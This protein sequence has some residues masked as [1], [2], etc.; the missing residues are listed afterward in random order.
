MTN[1][2]R[3]CGVIIDTGTS[4]EKCIILGTFRNAKNPVYTLIGGSINRNETPWDAFKREFYEETGMDP[5]Q[6]NYLDTYDF[7]YRSNNIRIIV[8]AFLCTYNGGFSCSVANNRIKTLPNC[9]TGHIARF[10][11]MHS[12]GGIRNPNKQLP[13][14]LRMREAGLGNYVSAMVAERVILAVVGFVRMGKHE[15]S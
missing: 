15:L 13:Q 1:P 14:N 9:E 4:G 6:L 5:L 8:R 2:D 12:L 11:L 10:P 7:C 3:A